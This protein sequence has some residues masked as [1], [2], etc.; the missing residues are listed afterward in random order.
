MFV[1][2][3]PCCNLPCSTMSAVCQSAQPHARLQDVR[4]GLSH[5]STDHLQRIVAQLMAVEQ[6]S[7]IPTW[8][9][10]IHRLAIETALLLD[11]VAISDPTA[12]HK[13]LDPRAF[14]KVKKL[15]DGGV[16]SASRVYQGVVLSKNLT[17]R[18]MP[19][20]IKNARILLLGGAIEY[21]KNTRLLTLDTIIPQ[22]CSM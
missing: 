6:I 21:Q 12:K 14:V 9:P 4:R 3:L 2:T 22:V 20:D 10:I 17:H 11:P 15:A 19:R 1:Q 8:Q 18:A 13:S 5:V 7:D 16:P